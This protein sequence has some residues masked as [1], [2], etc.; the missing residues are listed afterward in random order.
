[1]YKFLE[2]RFYYKLKRYLKLQLDRNQ[3]GFVPGMGT[4]VNIQLLIEKM[5][6]T[7]KKDGECCLF[8]DY[9]SAY[10]TVDKEKLY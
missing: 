1:M 6:Q 8:I 10:N 7:R 9:K 4:A 3:T 2:L 5:K